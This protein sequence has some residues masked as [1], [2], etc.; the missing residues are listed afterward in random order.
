MWQINP[1]NT[2]SVIYKL[3]LSRHIPEDT[4]YKVRCKALCMF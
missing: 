4:C 1:D 2:V 3:P